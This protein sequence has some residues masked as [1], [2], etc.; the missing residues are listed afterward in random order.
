MKAHRI[1]LRSNSFIAGDI[2]DDGSFN[3]SDLVLMQRCLLAA[4]DAELANW[5]AGDL[6]EDG[7]LD[8]FD[9]CLMRRMLIE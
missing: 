2:N 9:L 5:H 6:C 7:R 1:T 3:V 4:P 8:G